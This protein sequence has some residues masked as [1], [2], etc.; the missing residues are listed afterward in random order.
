M[1]AFGRIKGAFTKMVGAVRAD[2]DTQARFDSKYGVRPGQTPSLAVDMVKRVG[3]QLSSA[4]RVMRFF[5]EA[6]I[7]VAPMVMS[8][9][10]RHVYGSDIHWKAQLEPGVMLVHG[11]GLAISDHA[12]V[13]RGALVFQNVTLGAG[14]HP[15]TLEGGSPTIEE[16]VHIGPGAAIIGPVTIGARSKIMANCV[17]MRSVPPDSLVEAPEADVKSRARIRGPRGGKDEN[18]G[19]SGRAS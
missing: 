19:G 8:R 3:L 11:F 6:G 12:R 15:E 10:I 1:S 16:D 14:R 4:Y 5:D 7:P 13:A 18:K 2:Y 9:I 17:V